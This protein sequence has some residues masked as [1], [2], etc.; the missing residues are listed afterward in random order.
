MTIS[1]NRKA[2][3]EYH[4]IEQWVAGIVLFGNEVK[5]IRAGN[6]N[7]T[8]SFIYMKDGEV[9]LKNLK[10][11][12]YSQMHP[13]DKHEENRDKKLLLTKKQIQKISKELQNTG[14]TCIPLSVFV[15]KNKIKV[16][17]AVV[18]GKKNYDKR[19]SIKERD[20]KRE[21][22]RSL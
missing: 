12:R 18:K 1:T 16:N 10:V 5:S 9:W 8:D 20:I 14:I 15:Q 21:L 4:I 11:A 19:Q 22:Q 17:I 6:V 2:N 13:S 3:Y 7:I